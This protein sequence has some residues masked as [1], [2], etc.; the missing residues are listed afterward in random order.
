[1]AA[2]LHVVESSLTRIEASTQ[3]VNDSISVA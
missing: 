3:P 1:M 2:Q